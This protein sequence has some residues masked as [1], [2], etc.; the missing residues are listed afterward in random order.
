MNFS[1]M[2]DEYPDYEGQI[3]YVKEISPKVSN[4]TD[5]SRVLDSDNLI[6]KLPFQSLYKHQA[7]A[8]ETLEKN[9]NVCVTTPTSS[10]KTLIY[11]LDIARKYLSNNSSTSL[12]IYP[13]KALSRDQEEELSSIYDEL[14]LDI[15][16]GVYDG[17]SSRSEKRR[18]R[19]ESNVIITNFQGLNY[20]IPHHKKWSRIFRNLDTVVMDEA[21]TYTGI[22][23]IH[24]AWIVRRLKR[25]YEDIYNSTSDI[26]ISSAT[27][28]N[29]EEHSKNLTGESF[30]I[31]DNDGSPRGK[32]DLIIWNP[33]SY[34]DDDTGNLERRSSN[35]ESSDILSFLVSK[36]IQSLMFVPSRKSTEICAKWT[37]K[38]LEDNYAGF[39]DIEP[40]NAGHRKDDRREVENK[41]KS[42]EI[43]GVV[44]T[45]ALELG[46]DIG[47]VEATIMNGYP[48]RKSSFWQQAG[49]SGRGK[50][51]S[52]SI[53]TAR[54]N[55]IDQYIV[56]NPD[57]LLDDDVE[58]AVIDLSNRH[59]LKPHICAAANELPLRFTL[60]VANYF[61]EGPIMDVIEELKSEGFLTGDIL[62]GEEIKYVGSER[63][64]S[65]IDLY[66][67]SSEQF[68]VYIKSDED[69]YQLPS[70]DLSRAYQEFHPHAIYMYKG[71]QYEVVDF[72][73][74]KKEIYL[75]YTDAKYYT[76]SSRTV[77]I[78]DLEEQDSKELSDNIK[79]KKGKAVIS[80]SYQT[81]TRIYFNKSKKES[82]L[83]TGLNE[84]I[85]FKTDV[86]WFEINSDIATRIENKSSVDG[87]AGSLHATEHSLIKMSPTILAAEAKD[88]GGLSTP[89]H[90]LTNRA[91]IFI[92]D[93]VEG[94]VGFSHKIYENIQKLSA[95]TSKLLQNC[96]C[97]SDHG[98]PA[99]TMSPMCGDN[100]E[101]MDSKGAIYL[102]DIIG[103]SS[104]DAN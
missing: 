38:D 55:S 93:G 10:G 22:Q 3:E 91:T 34:I 47:N 36:D 80:E 11:A 79:L 77:D 78:Q 26:I 25:I 94:G 48:G 46:I 44:S 64:E 49:R 71:N 90:N 89:A 52:L 42:G 2:K 24:V 97:S 74:S 58:D 96:E 20:Y 61:S 40:Y 4:T 50:S 21:H 14:D 33:P 15:D 63:P 86:C 98:C 92:Y 59:I 37:E 99:C 13:T 18:I 17:D 67:S 1:K 103:D 84:P 72:D 101:P 100:N 65:N 83:P 95:K 31:I 16:I 102:L 5:P 85:E 76:Q 6:S 8:L 19:K 62:E 23:G 51:D 66:S 7:E 73:K 41:F 68:D 54:H 87:L 9:T 35:K 69:K 88:L 43:D 82:N 75:D 30:E 32:R 27:I 39:F 29:P 56:D 53:L 28:G 81:Y 12:L 104:T 70:V 45:T 57:F 60:D